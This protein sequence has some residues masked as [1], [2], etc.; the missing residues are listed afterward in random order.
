M[1]IYN[2]DRVDDVVSRLLGLAGSSSRKPIESLL[3]YFDREIR[4][5]AE[6][7]LDT[8]EEHGKD[9]ESVLLLM[10]RKCLQQA[11]QNDG[12]LQYHQY[13][14]EKE[15]HENGNQSIGS[16]GELEWTTFWKETVKNCPGPILFHP[17]ASPTF[18]SFDFHLDQTPRYLF[19][20]FDPKSSGHSDDEVVS[21]PASENRLVSSKMDILSLDD[22]HAFALVNLHMN[23]W[24]C[25]TK[26]HPNPD[27][28]MSWTSSLLYAVQYAL[29][30]RYHYGCSSEE[31]KICV[32]DTGDFPRGQ[33]VHAKRLLQ[34]YYHF[35]H[36]KDMRDN[37]DTRLLVYIYQNGEYLSQG[38]VRHGGRSCV[39]SLARLEAAGLYSLYPELADPCGHVQWGVRTANL[40]SMWANQEFSTYKELHTALTMAR[41][42]F[43]SFQQLDL[44]AIL[45]SFK[46]RELQMR[47]DESDE[48]EEELER[49]EEQFS[50]V[51]DMNKLPEWGRQPPEVRQY[52]L[53]LQTLQTGPVTEWNQ[54]SKNRL[55]DEEMVQALQACFATR[56][57]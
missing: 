3:S 35:L 15:T 11:T 29:Y 16:T 55:P 46:R 48:S 32:I 22:D 37:F 50:S 31:I 14:A 8:S 42:C 45:L 34:A 39:V 56:S 17:P 36:R 57:L 6:A 30:R 7:I 21:S 26:P 4:R 28:L 20:T 47:K 12:V 24:R 49:E 40:R 18:H 27:N 53:A 51:L 25:K 5:I 19:R 2:F 44:A 43:H 54:R 13:V 38:R 10:A 52:L 1:I 23:P 33:F 41:S 9:G